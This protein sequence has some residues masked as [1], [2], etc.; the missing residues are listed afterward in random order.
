MTADL[1]PLEEGKRIAH[2]Y[3]SKRGWAGEWRRSLNTQ[4]YPA[5]QR[6]EFE[7]KQRRCDQ[8]E[9]EAEEYFSG[10]YELWRK[11]DTAIGRE[12]RLGIWQVLGRRTD[13]G[14]YGKRIVD[15][16]KREFAPL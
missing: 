3:L 1:P 11:I 13:L 6:E 2:T 7:E 14:F 8:L 5:F 9:D 4:L 12:V 16:L 15:R 10:Q